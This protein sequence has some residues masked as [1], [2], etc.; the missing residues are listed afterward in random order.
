MP[1]ETVST[2]RSS[3]SRAARRR[4][5]DET[6]TVNIGQSVREGCLDASRLGMTARKHLH[7]SGCRQTGSKRPLSC[8][9]CERRNSV[10]RPPIRR[11]LAWAHDRA[12]S[13][14]K[15]SCVCPRR[16]VEYD[17][18]PLPFSPAL[19]LAPDAP[20]D[21]SRPAESSWPRAHSR[22]APRMAAAAPALFAVAASCPTSPWRPACCIA[23]PTTGT[24]AATAATRFPARPI[25]ARYHTPVRRPHRQRRLVAAVAIQPQ[26]RSP[27]A[28]GPK[29]PHAGPPRH[30]TS[31]FRDAVGPTHAA[32][33][34]PTETPPIA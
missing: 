14:L 2:A 7:K 16:H 19:A 32:P 3:P 33:P 23:H 28:R 6:F 11:S 25:A 34:S 30:R 10:G 29:S 27:G 12:V 17:A 22:H 4:Q 9:A 15:T 1:C 31:G 26:P 20:D 24:G 18:R 5:R 13:P 8:Y 21:P